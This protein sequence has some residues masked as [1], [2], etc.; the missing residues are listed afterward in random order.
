M[1]TLKIFQTSDVHGNIYPTNYV[2]KQDYGLAKASTLIK[3]NT[4]DSHKLIIDSGDLLQ[5]S[6]LAFYGAKFNK[7]NPSFIAALNAIGYDVITFGNHEFNYGQEF[8]VN[9][10]KQFNNTIVSAN[11]KGLDLNYKPYEIY[12]FD[13]L[14]VAVIGFTTDYVP[15]WE[16][17]QNISGLEFLDPVLTYGKYEAELKEQAD[18]IIVNYHGGFECNL[19]DNQTPTE[20]QTGENIASKLI[21]TFDSIDILLSGHQHRVIATQIDG[22]V[23]MQPG[24]NAIYVSEITID[25]ETKK[26]INYELKATKDYEA[27]Q[28]ILDLM[29]PL[30]DDCNVYLDTPLT[31]VNVDT[32]ISDVATARLN[33]SLFTN[34]LG[35]LFL[36]YKPSDF[37][38]VSLFDSAIGFE[39]NI[40]IRQVNQN[41]PFPNTMMQVSITGRD[42]IENIKQA[43]DYYTLKDGE[44]TINERYIFPKLKHYNYDM[45]YGLDYEVIV[46]QDDNEIIN[47]L[48]DN[49]PIELEREYTILVS[50]YRFNNRDDYPVYQNTKVLWESTEDA[51]EIL[52]SLLSELRELEI[53]TH[54]NYKITKGK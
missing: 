32:T 38:A 26:V 53:N 36:S 28:S 23:C 20:R 14:K 17:E 13:N 2:A 34:L 47:V 29:K 50:S 8:L 11:V 4:L 3:E 40:T 54:K 43:N 6:S 45:F 49:K 46:N 24:N 51:I 25:I 33:H 37:I 15:N 52:I 27:D 9:H 18:I 30:H 12:N 48:V 16:Q 42:M 44:I 39:K 1:K 19:E 10:Y 41:Y 21:Q 31:K 22:V 5:G 35:Q 7:T